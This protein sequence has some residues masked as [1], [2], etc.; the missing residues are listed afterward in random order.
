MVPCWKLSETW[1]FSREVNQVQSINYEAHWWLC[2]NVLFMQRI[3]KRALTSSDSGCCAAEEL[4]DFQPPA[5]FRAAALTDDYS[6]RPAH[7]WSC[8]GE[9]PCLL[10]RGQKWCWIMLCVYW[11]HRNRK[12]YHQLL[13]HQDYLYYLVLS[14]TGAVTKQARRGRITC[15]E[16]CLHKSTCILLNTLD[17][18]EHQP[19]RRISSMRGQTIRQSTP[20]NPDKPSPKRSPQ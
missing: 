5:L 9:R 4:F 13:K 19:R 18:F 14:F 7:Y 6:K 10:I 16:K 11:L 8:L 3:L 15:T 2:L 12:L 17:S 1:A 20:A